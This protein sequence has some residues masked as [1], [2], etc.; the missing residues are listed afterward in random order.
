MTFFEI[1]EYTAKDI[2]D[3]NRLWQESFGDPP[4]LIDRFFELLP[5]MGTGLVAVHGREIIGA[6][7]VL[8]AELSGEKPAVSLGYIYAVAV[9]PR[10]RSN[11]VGA[12]LTRACM[13]HSWAHG[14]QLCCTLPAEPKLYDWYKKI[15]GL[16]IVSCCTEE[17]VSPSDKDA[18][19]REIPA[20]EYGFRR[21]DILK[22]GRYVDF[23]YGYLQFQET[24]CKA[25]G[26]G[27]FA[28][29]EGIACGYLDGD[30]LLVKE[31]LNDAPEFIPALCRKL[32]A[33]KAL[34]RRSAASGKPFICAYEPVVFPADA[35]WDLA[36]D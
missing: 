10:W 17:T 8:S 31:A 30:T 35:V 27:M 28:C 15:S 19:I 7:Y 25:Y 32:G 1:R 18:D 11:G 4:S 20:D 3:L 5:S 29:G 36:L 33:K 6:A 12:E 21:Q 9:T 26:G 24:I 22:P 14:A 2:P 16:E 13:R 23:Y 34:V